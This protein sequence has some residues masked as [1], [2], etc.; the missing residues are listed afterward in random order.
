MR[1]SGFPTSFGNKKAGCVTTLG[2]VGY[3]AG[4]FEVEAVELGL[5]EIDWAGVT[6]SDDGTVFASARIISADADAAPRSSV[7]IQAFVF[8]TGVEVADGTNLSGMTFRVLGIG[9]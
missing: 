1:I 3:A 5:K 6:N 8:S 9:I 4:G 7:F 2:P